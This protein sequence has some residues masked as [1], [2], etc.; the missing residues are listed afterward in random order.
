MSIFYILIMLLIL[1]L[2]L[3]YQSYFDRIVAK[4]I[5]AN[6]KDEI[7]ELL[8][9][10]FEGLQENDLGFLEYKFKSK[11]ILFEYYCVRVRH[12]FQ[13][14]LKI[15]LDISDLEEDIKK[16]CK[17]HF[18]CFNVDERDYV[19]MPVDIFCTTMVR[20]VKHSSKTIAKIIADTEDYISEKREERDKKKE[21]K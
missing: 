12:G 21:I 16:L 9:K 2:V 15:Y 11:T 17:I 4:R 3:L 14:H 7:Y 10:E 18:Y 19:T 20:L 13:D 6:R 8:K 1:V 5:I